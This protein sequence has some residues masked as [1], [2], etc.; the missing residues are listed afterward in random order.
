[1]QVNQSLSILFYR[2]TKKL[3]KKGL[4]P[5]YCRVTIDGLS[6]EISTGCYIKY[7]D[8]ESDKKIVL[9]TCPDHTKINKKL[10]QMK[11]DLERHFDLVTAKNGLAVPKQVLESYKSPING[12]RQITERKE[13]TA[14]SIALDE[15]IKDTIKYQ[16]NAE[17]F[18]KKDVI[19]PSQ[20]EL[21]K[22]EKADLIKRA[23][24]LILR[25]RK[26][27]DNKEWTKTIVVATDEFLFHFL[28]LV[29]ANER[30]WPTFCKLITAKS[31]LQE[32]MDHRYTKEDLVLSDLEYSFISEFTKHIIIK[33]KNSH[34]TVWKYVQIIK[35]IID[36]AVAHGWITTNVFT[37][38]T[39]NYK[40]PD[41]KIW[42]TM[43]EMLH[44]IHFDFKEQEL[45]QIR[46]VFVF[47]SFAGLSYAELYKLKPEHLVTGI[48]DK[49]WID[50]RRQKTSVSETLPLLPI[51]VE[52]LERFKSNP[53]CV[54]KNKCLWVPSNQ[55]YNR[56]LKVIGEKTGIVCMSNCHQARYFFANEIAH[57]NGVELKIIGTLLGQKDG[58]SINTYVK[59]TKKTISSSMKMV[60]DKLYAEDGPLARKT[61]DSEDGAKIISIKKK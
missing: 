34:N 14:F 17:L 16:R 21:I 3:N 13:N 42:P 45:S 15:L 48:D 58:R 8:W 25:G 24:K 54:R 2:K 26:I 23:E 27:W 51:C 57:A 50:Q 22:E 30:A 31:R 59:P 61:N 53:H 7:D 4:L 43:A 35:E 28:E 1:M 49:T 55:Y 5:L 56:S 41:G 33:H 19:R 29:L 40:E 60:E 37:L 20:Q 52:I 38:F 47:Q 36:R 18:G 6:D 44:L 39:W 46:D 11:T 9:S 10:R 32:F 12:H